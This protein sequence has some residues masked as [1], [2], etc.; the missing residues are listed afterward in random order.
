MQITFGLGSGGPLHF[1]EEYFIEVITKDLLL[2][3]YHTH[4]LSV[5]MEL[6]VHHFEKMH[7]YKSSG[8]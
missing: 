4:S 5:G 8:C 2:C 1:Q 7:K 3:Y 6:N